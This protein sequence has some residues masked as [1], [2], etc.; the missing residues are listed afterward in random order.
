MLDATGLAQEAKPKKSLAELI[1]QAEKSVVL[2]DVEGE[3]GE[4]LG[5]GSGFLIDDKGLVVTSNHVVDQAV[6]VTA[7]FRDGQKVAVKGPRAIDKDRDLAILELEKR[8][9]GPALCAGPR[10][11]PRVG[12][13]VTAIGHPRGLEFSA[14][15]GIVSGIRTKKD[16]AEKNVPKINPPDDTIWVQT[17]AALIPG[18]SGG[19]LLS[20]DGK[21]LGVSAFSSPQDRIGFAVHVSHVIDLL[22]RARME[23]TAAFAG[24][25]LAREVDDPFA[26]SLSDQRDVWRIHERVTAMAAHDDASQKPG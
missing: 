21:V 12:D 19:P 7:K 5:M 9:P 16:Q 11:P 13:S 3:R 22:A 4:K 6:K 8:Q 24:E 20:E 18:N 25:P 15:D 2:L 1:G 14:T 26:V 10:T 23:K 17:S